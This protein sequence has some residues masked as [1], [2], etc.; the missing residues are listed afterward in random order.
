MDE[1]MCVV[2][3]KLSMVLYMALHIILKFFHMQAEKH[4]KNKRKDECAL[5]YI[6]YDTTEA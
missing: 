1:R 3:A 5:I 2:C 6:A 4:W